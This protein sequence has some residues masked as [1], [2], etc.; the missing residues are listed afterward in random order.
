MTFRA[1]FSNLAF[2]AALLAAVSLY[3]T[4]PV[5]RK[6]GHRHDEFFRNEKQIE[7]L[8]LGS[9]HNRAIHFPSLG[10]VGHSFMIGGGDIETAHLMLRSSI[11]RI[12]NLKYVLMPL[13]PG[14]LH[15]SVR[16]QSKF[17]NWIPQSIAVDVPTPPA[18]S[19][20][21]FSLRELWDIAS[22]QLIEPVRKSQVWLQRRLSKFLRKAEQYYFPAEGSIRN[23]CLSTPNTGTQPHEFG[24]PHGYKTFL[25]EEHCIPEHAEFR[26]KR[27]LSQADNS[28][29]EQNHTV[30]Y[31]MLQLQEIAKL[32]E[33]HGALFVVF[34]PPFVAEYFEHAA[35]KRFWRIE[36]TLIADIA[37]KSPSMVFLDYHDLF[38][39]TGYLEDNKYFY[40]SDH[41][42][43]D[44]AIEFSTVLGSDL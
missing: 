19:L 35:L 10:Y 43:L 36:R 29:L 7:V 1:A 20:S 41:L 22:F 5:E 33:A 9:S 12:V 28:F 27:R 17:G 25:M 37:K 6:M 38:Y 21:S 11:D 24:V 23:P 30:E 16:H 2:L 8:T 18:E 3:A 14:L 4:N 40:N 13:S 42:N 39:K 26:V 44:G 15:Y 34:V 32:V 31:S